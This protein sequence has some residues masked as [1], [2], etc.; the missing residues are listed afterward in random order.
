MFIL[1]YFTKKILLLNLV[2][3]HDEDIINPRGAEGYCSCL[4]QYSSGV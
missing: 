4:V 3:H 1:E 2:N